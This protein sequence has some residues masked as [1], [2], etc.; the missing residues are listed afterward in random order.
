MEALV[1]CFCK[2]T[3][4]EDEVGNNGNWIYIAGTGGQTCC[5]PCGAAHFN[6]KPLHPEKHERTKKVLH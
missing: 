5:G 1:C 6:V 4:Q 2:R 3:Q